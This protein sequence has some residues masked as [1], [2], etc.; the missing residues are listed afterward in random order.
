MKKLQGQ[1]VSGGIAFGELYFYK[2][3]KRET[4]RYAV[5]DTGKQRIRFEKALSTAVMQL[6]RL[7][8]EAAGKLGAEN[9]AL[10]E[11]HRMMLEDPDYRDS[12]Y[13]IIDEEKVNAE[14]AVAATSDSFA[15]LFESMDDAY[16]QARSA[17]VRDVSERVIDILSG[18]PEESAAA[19]GPVIL[20]AHDLA[21]SETVRLDKSKI[22]AIVTAGGSVNSHTAIFARALA[23]PA[24]AGVRGIEEIPSGTPVA[25]DGFSGEVFVDPDE[26]FRGKLEQRQRDLRRHEEELARF[27]G[28][29]A[30]TAGGKRVALYANIG[31][32]GEAEAALENDAEGIGLFRSEFLYLESRD[33]PSE[34]S[35]FRAYSQ[36]AEKMEG[37]PVI[38]RTLDIGADKQVPY[39]N[40]P[41][42]ENPALGMRAIRICL[43]RPEIFRTQLRAL[44]RASAYG[45]ISIMFPMIASVEEVREARALAGEVRESLAA[46]KIPFD[47]RVKL[48]IM[49]ETPASA[50]ISDLLAREVDFFSIGT[51]D[52]IQYTLAADRQNPH[53]GRF[54]NPRH[55]AVLRLIETTVKNAHAAGIEVGICGE[56]AADTELTARFVEMGV[57]ELSMTPKAILRVKEAIAAC[58]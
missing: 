5:S 47:P 30:V 31:N 37:K 39:F 34:E 35:Q 10:F 49:I 7:A 33:Y 40:L 55:E 45:R 54:E 6:D 32:P 8:R 19:P 42:E 28:L 36:V 21:P 12:V 16:M 43:T 41:H 23:I 50:V 18:A 25:V 56:L 48:G 20:A 9:A 38:I 15:A 57:D 29:P 2:K 46:E 24:V 26:N 27:R 17:D 58:P 44:Y 22:L 53:I 14:Y 13:R 11:V 52:L 4:S 51:N 1:A 3:T